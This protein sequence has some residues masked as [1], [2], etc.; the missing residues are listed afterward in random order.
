MVS[1]GFARTA[2]KDEVDAQF[3]EVRK[4]FA[5]IDEEFDEAFRRL[6]RIEKRLLENH[7]NRI[8]R[9]EQELKDVRETL[10]V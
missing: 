9:L 6:D 2:Q 5:D 3:Q 4:G 7:D 8:S 1:E 10:K